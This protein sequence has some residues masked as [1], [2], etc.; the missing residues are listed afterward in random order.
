MSSSV[1]LTS[2]TQIEGTTALLFICSVI[3]FFCRAN[4]H[5]CAQFKRLC[6]V[7]YRSSKLITLK[8]QES[9]C[10]ASNR[11]I[12]LYNHTFVTD[13]LEKRG[14]FRIGVSFRKVFHLIF[15]RTIKSC[16]RLVSTKVD[17]ST[18]TS[19]FSGQL[20]LVNIRLRPNA[21][22]KSP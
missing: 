17:I 7:Y 6:G 1:S 9:N 18:H 3:E 19:I 5:P 8:I 20:F 16:A 14:D 12:A 13:S 4:S 11:N 21:T 2:N 10:R 15:R 22:L